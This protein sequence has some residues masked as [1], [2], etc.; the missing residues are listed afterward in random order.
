MRLDVPTCPGHPSPHGSGRGRPP[1]AGGA[2]ARLAHN[3]FQE[4]TA[5]AHPEVARSLTA[6]GEAGA[7]VALLSG[8]GSTCFGLFDSADAA[9]GAA[10]VLRRELGWPCRTA[11][12]LREL[13]AG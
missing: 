8:S 4:V 6:L 1:K 12:T 2:L 3:D 10:D 13:P 7:E 11:R 9:R 5:R